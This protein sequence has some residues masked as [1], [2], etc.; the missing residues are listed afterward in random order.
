MLEDDVLGVLADQL[1]LAEF[2]ILAESGNQGSAFRFLVFGRMKAP[3]FVAIRGVDVLVGECKVRPTQLFAKRFDCI[4]DFECMAYLA[5]TPDSKARL[6]REACVRM[7]TLGVRMR[8]SR[9]NIYPAIISAG[10]LARYH[11]P[12]CNAGVLLITVDT[13]GQTII[14]I[15]GYQPDRLA[16]ICGGKKQLTTHRC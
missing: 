5:R 15:A 11:A 6:A 13:S 10:S 7:N 4:S 9:L 1:R 3:D 12:A 8:A 16:R 14:D 2:L